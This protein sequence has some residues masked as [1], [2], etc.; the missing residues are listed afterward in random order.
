MSNCKNCTFG[1]K[2]RATDLLMSEKYLSGVYESFLMEAASPEVVRC[3][4]EQMRDV[5]TAQKQLFEDMSSRGWY[6]TP[7]AEQAKLQN[8]R[9]QFATMVS[10]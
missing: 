10:E 1:E 9:Q 6:P 5:Q 3:L 2:E 4:F 7:A 8:T